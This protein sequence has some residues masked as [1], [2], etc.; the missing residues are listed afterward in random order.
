MLKEKCCM[1]FVELEKAF[2]IVPWK[3][4]ELTMRKK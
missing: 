4:L 1:C 3:V 2:D